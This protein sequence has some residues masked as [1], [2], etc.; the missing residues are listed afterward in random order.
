MNT[1][2]TNKQARPDSQAEYRTC[3]FRI[4]GR[5]RTDNRRDYSQPARA[6]FE[7]TALSRTNAITP[8]LQTTTTAE[9]SKNV[10]GTSKAFIALSAPTQELT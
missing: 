9:G 2:A 7:S 4:V 10:E 6:P 8:H 5:R 3:N 1:D